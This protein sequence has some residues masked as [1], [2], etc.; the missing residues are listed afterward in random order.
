MELNDSREELIIFSLN[1]LN[2]ADLCQKNISMSKKKI[3]NAQVM[4]T[5]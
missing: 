3:K 5:R 2:K 1:C 4:S